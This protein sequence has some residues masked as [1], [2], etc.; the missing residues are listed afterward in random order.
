[1]QSA[2]GVR[3]V[4]QWSLTLQPSGS[5]YFFRYGVGH[6]LARC[7]FWAIEVFGDYD[8]SPL[9]DGSREMIFV[10]AEADN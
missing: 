1:M 9:A 4:W 5:L 2:P 10:A 7:G 8:R 3:G 6:L